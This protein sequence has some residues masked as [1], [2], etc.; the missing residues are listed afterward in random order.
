VNYDSY[1]KFYLYLFLT[2]FHNRLGQVENAR[3][4]LCIPGV[5]LDPAELQKLQAVEK[6]LNKCTDARRINDWK[7]AL[8]EANA[9]IAAGADFSPQVETHF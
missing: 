4:H 8:R 1:F 6:H 2:Q 9:A 3:R 5:Q 7:S